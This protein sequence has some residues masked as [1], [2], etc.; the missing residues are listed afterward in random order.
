[1][2]ERVAVI[3]SGG[4]GKTTVALKLSEELG[5]KLVEAKDRCEL[6]H[7]LGRERKVIKEVRGL[8]PV[9]SKEKCL[10]CNLCAAVCPERAMV[11]DWDGYPLA[12]EGLCTA[13]GSCVAACPEGALREEE[14]VVARVYEIGDVVQLE[15][16]SLKSLLKGLEPPWVLDTDRPEYALFAEVALVLYV[17]ERSKVEAL[18]VAKFLEKENVR[19]ILVENKSASAGPGRIPEGLPVKLEHVLPLLENF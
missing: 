1:L 12:L 4:T 5:F 10:R 3:G 16:R 15:G 14:Q 7:F 18:R 19:T 9:V 11:R 6:H 13:C 8:Y 17:D 2:V